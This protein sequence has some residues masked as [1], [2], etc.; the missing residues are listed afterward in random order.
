MTVVED[1]VINPGEFEQWLKV[2]PE[3]IDGDATAINKVRTW[4]IWEI[5][6]PWHWRQSVKGGMPNDLW[7]LSEPPPL[8]LHH[9]LGIDLTTAV[10]WRMAGFD[11]N[12]D[13][14]FYDLWLKLEIEPRRAWTLYNEYKKWRSKTPE[15]DGDLRETMRL[16]KLFG[17][18][19]SMDNFVKYRN[20]D[21]YGVAKRQ[22]KEI[23]Q[24]NRWFR[25]AIGH[26]KAQILD[27]VP[28]FV[29]RLLH[30]FIALVS[31]Q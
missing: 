10:H 18:Y 19:V 5:R 15:P 4:I 17:I 3:L 25:L 9:R 8:V 26:R 1:L 14:T 11:E 20:L 30:N 12:I 29:Y 2:F 27:R 28:H 7:P 24:S 16:L 22:A 23:R 21:I 13:E 6:T 31:S